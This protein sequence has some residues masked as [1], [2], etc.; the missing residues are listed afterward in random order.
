[1]E[2]ILLS[3]VKSIFQQPGLNFTMKQG[4]DGRRDKWRSSMGLYF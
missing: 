2:N 4:A 1:M 3:Y